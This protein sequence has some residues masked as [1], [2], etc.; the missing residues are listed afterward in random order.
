MRARTRPGPVIAVLAGHCVLGFGGGCEESVTGAST[1]PDTGPAVRPVATSEATGPPLDI[2]LPSGASAIT[3]SLWL[4]REG[5]AVRLDGAEDAQVGEV[6][7]TLAAGLD[8]ARLAGRTLIGSQ[9]MS[10][11]ALHVIGAVLTMPQ[12]SA[13]DRPRSPVR[14]HADR[15]LPFRAV[16]PVLEHLRAVRER[17]VRV[18][19]ETGAGIDIVLVRDLPAERDERDAA[20][21]WLGDLFFV[22]SGEGVHAW[23][24]PRPPGSAPRLGRAAWR[25][26]SLAP[27]QAR[28]REL[29]LAG[30][31]CPAV[32]TAQL[33]EAAHRLRTLGVEMCQA[34]R[35]PFAATLAPADDTP[36]EEVVRVLTAAR[37][38]EPCGGPVA[39]A[40]LDDPT[41]QKDACDGPFP[42][43]R[44]ADLLRPEPAPAP[45]D[46]REAAPTAAAASTGELVKPTGP[47][48]FEV[49]RRAL[50]TA[51]ED[52]EALSRA[53]RIIPNYVMGRPQGLKLVGL[54]PGSIYRALGLRSGDIVL[55]INGR[56]VDQLPSVLDAYDWLESL[57]GPSEATLT[58]SRR[59][60][61]IQLHYDLR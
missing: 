46:A 59:G 47:H 41:L 4:G 5:W 13:P 12:T 18:M 39:L 55:A 28:R 27:A 45:A 16:R 42:A 17:R 53:A 10:D 61:E 20:R 9:A 31:V 43:I 1:G 22:W 52:T 49:D 57:E 44:I 11:D 37:P 26:P 6:L 35:Q 2:E 21:R 25:R 14:L 48:R 30:P 51:L 19:D 54:R 40:Y 36:W 29:T 60:R 38:P 32:P 8:G 3:R 58:I 23:L 50:L 7:E 56:T 33:G 24:V 15:R 34:V